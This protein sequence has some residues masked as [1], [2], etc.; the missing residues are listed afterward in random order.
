MQASREEREGDAKGAAHRKQA[1]TYVEA[2]SSSGGGRGRGVE[3]RDS[4]ELLGEGCDHSV[5][6][7][8]CHNAHTHTHTKQRAHNDCVQTHERLMCDMMWQWTCTQTH[9]SMY[10]CTPV[11]AVPPL[12]P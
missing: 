5:K 10:T 4:P 1:L 6:E 7:Y 9:T 11:M 2:H 3:P 12:L 8:Y